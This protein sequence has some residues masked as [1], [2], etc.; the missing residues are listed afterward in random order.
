MGPADTSDTSMLKGPTPGKP[1]YHRVEMKGDGCLDVVEGV[2]CVIAQKSMRVLKTA[3]LYRVRRS[4]ITPEH[5]PAADSRQ[6]ARGF[7]AASPHAPRLKARLK[8]HCLILV[9]LLC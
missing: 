4:P 8:A 6:W 3:Q 1:P 9:V 2:R 7:A 5:Y